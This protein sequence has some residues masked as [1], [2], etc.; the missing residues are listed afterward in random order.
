MTTEYN[1]NVRPFCSQSEYEG[2]ID[3]FLT[4][5]D[6]FLRGM[7]VDRS[8]LPERYGWLQQLLADHAKPDEKK[9]R[10]YLAWICN[11]VQIGHVSV[12]K[13][14]FGVEAYFHLHMWRADLRKAGFGI[15]LCEQSIRFY[16]ERLHLQ[17]LWCEPYVNNP[18]PNRTVAKLGFVFVKRHRTVPGPINFE[19]EVNL[20]C[21][22]RDAWLS[23]GSQP[24]G[25]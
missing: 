21:L 5:D 17:R 9:D 4:A 6:A 13:I 15:A 2:M 11:A 18:A 24:E 12:N 25:L 8:L 1:L 22:D 23:R 14:I 20:Y 7:G 3:Y 16:F 10:L 19:Q